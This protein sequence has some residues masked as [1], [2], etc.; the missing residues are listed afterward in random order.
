MLSSESFDTTMQS[1]A[2][3]LARHQSVPA[4]ASRTNFEKPLST[5]NRLSLMFRGASPNPVQN[6]EHKNNKGIDKALAK[7]IELE[8]DCINNLSVII[9][10][11]EDVLRKKHLLS[12]AKIDNL[13]GNF[14]ELFEVHHKFLEQ[15]E[16]IDNGGDTHGGLGYVIMQMMNKLDTPYTKCCE[17]QV[18]SL[19]ACEEVVDNHLVRTFLK[20]AGLHGSNDTL[21]AYMAN[22]FDTL[23][24]YKELFMSVCNEVDPGD[25]EYALFLSASDKINRLSQ[26][27]R[28]AQLNWD[29]WKEV[30][31]LQA[32]LDFSELNSAPQSRR[33]SLRPDLNIS[34]NDFAGLRRVLRDDRFVCIRESDDGTKEDQPIA[35]ILLTDLLLLCEPKEKDGQE[36]YYLLKPPLPLE[37]VSLEPHFGEDPEGNCMELE[38][39]GDERLLLRASESTDKDSWLQEFKTYQIAKMLE[40]TYNILDFDDQEDDDDMDNRHTMNDFD[41]DMGDTAMVLDSIKQTLDSLK[42]DMPM[43]DNRYSL[44]PSMINFDSISLSDE[45]LSILETDDR[46]SIYSPVSEA[47]TFEKRSSITL[48]PVDISFNSTPIMEEGSSVD[49]RSSIISL[50]NDYFNNPELITRTSTEPLNLP[51]SI[52]D[53]RSKT[54]SKID[55]FSPD[56][57]LASTEMVK[58]EPPSPP[59]TESTFSRLSR[60]ISTFSRRS[61]L[62]PSEPVIE[63]VELN[64]PPPQPLPST[65]FALEKQKDL[66]TSLSEEV[67][68]KTSPKSPTFAEQDFEERNRSYSTSSDAPKVNFIIRV[69]KFSLLVTLLFSDEA[70]PSV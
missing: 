46:T 32:K 30:K 41:T 26:I 34:H 3:K 17:L 42:D 20:E 5:F 47:S 29:E 18:K 38:V 9:Q 36:V 33:L 2:I 54:E 40:E 16:E 43:A 22:P 59:A 70:W 21:H 50:K 14:P 15:L 56:F 11:S 12:P 52:S 27:A 51:Q 45:P 69:V 1:E 37:N 35:L 53:R 23:F 7:L 13:L 55:F 64:T 49:I 62:T 68:D 28:T 44:N 61:S 65:N 6:I 19:D 31:Q 67:T 10:C 57:K 60:R 58:E 24:Q 8:K 25:L 63:T 66:P 4:V 48:S 39:E